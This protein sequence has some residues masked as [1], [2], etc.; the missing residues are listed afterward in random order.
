MPDTVNAANATGFRI[1]NETME[2]KMNRGD[3]GS[4][5]VQLTRAS[6]D[7]WTDDDRALFTIKNQQ[8]ET[9]LQRIYRLDDQWEVGDGIFLVEFHNDDTETWESGQYSV[10]IRA[11]ISPIWNGTAPT[12]RCVNALATG[13][14]QMIEGSIVRTVIQSQLT[15]DNIE[16]EI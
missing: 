7:A 14:P 10:E 5:F 13:V 8:G 3:T 11:N 4:F 9:V 12:G 6:G 15:I 16:G 2:I 1:D